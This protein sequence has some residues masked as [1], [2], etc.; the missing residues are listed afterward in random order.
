MVDYKPNHRGIGDM[1]RS[2][3]ILEHLLR[4][5]EK[6]RVTA[7]ETAPVGRDRTAGRY[8][9]SFHIRSSHHGG[10][11]RDRA[12]VVVFNDAPE[13]QYVEWGQHGAEPYHILLRAAVESRLL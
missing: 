2:D 8:K 9:E 12:E 7:E 11:T 5:G 13:A 1:L 4:V 6:I 10:A 3:M